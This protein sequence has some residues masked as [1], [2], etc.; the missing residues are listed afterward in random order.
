MRPLFFSFFFFFPLALTL[1]H[2]VA[3]HRDVLDTRRPRSLNSA[4]A[5]TR[6]ASKNALSDEVKDI[7][8]I[9]IVLVASIDGSFHA[10]NRTSGQRLW[11]MSAAAS[12][13]PSSLAPLV[14][15]KHATIDYDLT[16]DDDT[17]QELYII[18]P[19]TGDIYLMA[20]PTSP[21]Q[22]L[23]ISMS[24]L[25]E[26]SPFKFDRE[27]DE[28]VF[29]GK[30][31]TLLLSI[32]LETGKVKTIN[33]ECPWNPFEDLTQKDEIDLDELEDHLPG[34]DESVPTEVFVGRTGESFKWIILLNF[35]TRSKRLP[36]RHLHSLPIR[37]PTANSQSLFFLLWAQHA[38]QYRPSRLPTHSRQHLH[39]VPAQRS[40]HVIQ[41]TRQ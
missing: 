30:K 17:H 36:R 34:S 1:A 29:V 39:R 10:V 38:G 3:L 14:R 23:S 6:A 7:E 35:R 33:A 4:R 41:S 20:T 9:D 40:N 11:S 8:L 2:S 32:E 27:D 24:Q 22:P 13:I 12:D 19:Q 15:T 37:T 5:W 16:D 25:V 26:L 28:R 31:E 18:E 21:L